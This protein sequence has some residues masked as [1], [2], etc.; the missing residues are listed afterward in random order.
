MNLSR[1]SALVS[2][3]AFSFQVFVLEPWHNQI[4]NELSELKAFLKNK[5]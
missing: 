5:K 2:T 3:M 4:S 1:Y